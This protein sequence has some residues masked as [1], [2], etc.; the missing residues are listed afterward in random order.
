MIM[1]RLKY[2]RFDFRIWLHGYRDSENHNN[3]YNEAIY[4]GVSSQRTNFLNSCVKNYPAIRKK[5]D[6]QSGKYLSL[7]RLR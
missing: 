4:L 6:K 2:G 7:S 3:K 1:V 5:I